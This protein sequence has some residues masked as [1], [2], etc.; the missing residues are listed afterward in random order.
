LFKLVLS[1]VLVHDWLVSLILNH[2]RQLIMEK[3]EYRGR[4]SSLHGKQ[5]AEKKRKG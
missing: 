1:E 5:E 4:G 3:G 2:G